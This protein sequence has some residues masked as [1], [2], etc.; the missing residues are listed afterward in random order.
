MRLKKETEIRSLL[1]RA[2]EN[3]GP[4][5]SRADGNVYAPV[6]F[7][8]IHVVAV[9][10]ELGASV[11][12]QPLLRDAA[13]F[14]LARQAPDGLFRHVKN[15]AKLPCVSAK[16]LVSLGRIG[17]RRDPRLP[18]SYGW[19]LE[20]QTDDGGWRCNMARLGKSPI[21]D[22]SNPGTTLDVLDAFRFRRNGR[23]DVARL[24]RGVEFLLRHWETRLPLGPC[25]FGIVSRFLRV[26]YPFLRYNLFHYVYVLSHY[27]KVRRDRRF[28]EAHQ[29]LARRLLDGKM[30]V[31]APHQAWQDSSFARRGQVSELATARWR[32]IER[33]LRAGSRRS[34]ARPRCGR[35][36][37]GSAGAP[38]PRHKP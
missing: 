38:R 36:G 29:E 17:V 37:P 27:P 3:G 4:F 24:N 9:L 30:R 15:A 14:L 19:F 10:G 35:E 22:A 7:S 23:N 18:T 12:N 31:E 6:G 11:R 21:T 28:R 33:Q 16:V 20:N 1:R 13:E 5:W 2:K 26:E 34:K 32:E 8:T 25:A